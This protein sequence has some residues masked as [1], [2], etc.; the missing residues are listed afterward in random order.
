M[1]ACLW[2]EVGEGGREVEISILNFN[3][4]DFVELFFLC[5]SFLLNVY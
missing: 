5:V 3:I 2:G 4:F 1:Q